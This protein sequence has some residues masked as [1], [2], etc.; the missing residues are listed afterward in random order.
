MPKNVKFLILSIGALF[1]VHCP[2]QKFR[3]S[4]LLSDFIFKSHKLEKNGLAPLNFSNFKVI[5]TSVL[6]L[7]ETKQSFGLID[8]EL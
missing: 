3:H 2:L 7:L 4:I 6:D 5:E 8:Q 1:E